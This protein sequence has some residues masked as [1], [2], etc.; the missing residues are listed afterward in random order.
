MIRPRTALLA[1]LALACGNVLAAPQ[2]LREAYRDDFLVGTAVNDAIVSGEDAAQQA[3]AVRHFNAVTLENSMKAEVLHPE[4]GR[5]DFERADAF[6]GFGRRHGMFVVGHTLVWHNQTPDWFFQDDAG[7]PADTATMRGR[8][9]Q[10]IH[11]VAGRYAGKVHAWDVVNEQ[12]GE[13][14][15]YRDTAWV[16]A[17]GGDGDA[18]L[19]DAFRFASEA[20]PDAELYY[21]D[22]NAWRPEKVAGIVRMVEML[23]A[24][25]IRIDGV[26]IQGH[27]GLNY[28]SLTEI[29]AAI[30]AYHA[31][32]VKVMVTELDVDVLPLTKEGQIIGQCMLH[33]QFQLPEFKRFL[34][35]YREGLPDEVQRQLADRY[36]E[37]FALFH[38]KRDKLARVAVWG[39]AD[40]MS[41][42]N[43]Y[44]IPGRTNYP[45]LFDRQRQPKPALEAVLRVPQGR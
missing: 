20:A 18:L 43:G 21:N 7:R 36:A 27:W 45:L 12:I 19:R 29:E 5:W 10:Y 42:K 35:P 3:L 15:R 8:L 11:T 31:A 4:P 38:R 1:T 41:W 16:R 24:H 26:G 13:D 2:T 40:D 33:P 22:F 6:V 23:R 37:L 17:Y 25:G 28:P 44:P 14:G 39:I 34:D 9:R 30:D 32:G